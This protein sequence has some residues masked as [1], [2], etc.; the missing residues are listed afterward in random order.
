MKKAY[1]HWKSQAGSPYMIGEPIEFVDYIR[2]GPSIE[3]FIID[4]TTYIGEIWL[5]EDESG[6]QV[7]VKLRTPYNPD[8]FEKKGSRELPPHLS[9]NWAN[10]VVDPKGYYQ[11]FINSEGYV[12]RTEFKNVELEEHSKKEKE[13]TNLYK[14]VLKALSK[15]DNKE[16]YNYVK[17]KISHR[18]RPEYAKFR[19]IQK[20]QKQHQP[21]LIEMVKQLKKAP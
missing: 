2:K 11:A 16:F 3:K 14:K 5:L 17:L 13:L 12:K 1:K 20:I 10:P 18:V 6:Q 7:E 8:L 19:A 9:D 15:K 4:G 21:L